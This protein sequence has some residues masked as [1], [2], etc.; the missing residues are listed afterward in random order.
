MNS[1]IQFPWIYAS[2]RRRIHTRTPH[3]YLCI[4]EL[5]LN[6]KAYAIRLNST[7][8]TQ[9]RSSDKD[10]SH[11]AC[12]EYIESGLICCGLLWK[13][14]LLLLLLLQRF[15]LLSTPEKRDH[16]KWDFSS[17]VYVYND[18]IYRCCVC[19]CAHFEFGLCPIVTISRTHTIRLRGNETCTFKWVVKLLQFIIA[20]KR[21]NLWVRERESTYFLHTLVHW[22]LW[23]SRS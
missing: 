12:G 11:S 2:S 14:L 9:G 19:V 1:I 13:L 20:E 21:E 17:N 8:L 6:A 10:P 18:S 7:L 4:C 3:A 23:M 5:N 16:R 15:W 22:M